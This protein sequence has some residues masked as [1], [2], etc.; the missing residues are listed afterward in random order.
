M[1]DEPQTIG[2]PVK[3]KVQGVG[4]VT[5]PKVTDDPKEEDE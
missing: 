3:V 2:F 1:A 5:P 4:T